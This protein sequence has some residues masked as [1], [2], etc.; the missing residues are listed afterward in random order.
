MKNEK[1]DHIVN[2]ILLFPRNMLCLLLFSGLLYL[3]TYDSKKS[4]SKK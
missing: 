3:I 2:D 1:L 4:E